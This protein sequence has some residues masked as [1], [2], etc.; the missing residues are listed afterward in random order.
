MRIYIYLLSFLLSLTSLGHVSYAQAILEDE[1]NKGTNEN[2]VQ[3]DTGEINKLIDTLESESARKDFIDNLKTLTEVNDN[4]NDNDPA[5]IDLS[6]VT[7]KIISYYKGFVEDLGISEGLFGQ[8]VSTCIAIIVWC[9]FVWLT[10]KLAHLLRDKLYTYRNKYQLNHDRFR[11]YARYIRYAGYILVTGV[12]LYTIAFI[13]GF[14]AGSV[15]IGNTGQ[16]ILINLL[17]VIVVTLIAIIMWEAINTTLEHYIRN[18]DTSHSNRMI[19][20]IPILRNVLF[21]AFI[22]LFALVLLSEIGVNI[23]PLMA[24]AGVLGIAIGLGAQTMIKDFITGFTIILEDLVQVGDVANV[25][26]KI[27]V[28]EKI[29][30]RKIQLRDLAGIV[31]TVPFSE[32]SIVEN[33]S[34]E[35]SFYVMDIGVAYRENTDEV[36]SYLKEIDDEMRNDEEYKDLILEPLEIL[37]VDAFADSAV[38]IKARIKTQPIKQW[39]VGREFNRRMKFKFDEKGVEIPFPH[40]TLYFGEDKKGNAPAASVKILN[41]DLE[42]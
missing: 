34:K 14:T 1:Q 30:I 10:R 5:I 22:I 6:G 4:K 7:G 26:G 16:T 28:V 35:F 23:V 15:S 18:L 25:A 20:I 37:G 12:T 40:Q 8:I 24:G 27:G 41:N 21:I 9:F 36:I 19:T 11:L 39:T 29:T 17:N 42:E 2:S 13:W 38:V 31:Y 3:V 33:W 32:I